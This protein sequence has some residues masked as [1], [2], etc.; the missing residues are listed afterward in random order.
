MPRDD[1]PFKMNVQ[2]SETQE[3]P[4][5]PPKPPSSHTSIARAAG[6]GKG[7]AESEAVLK[8]INALAKELE[9]R[10]RMGEGE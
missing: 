10:E 5:H 4:G 6:A 8:M 2:T 7:G 1:E 9:V 3:Q